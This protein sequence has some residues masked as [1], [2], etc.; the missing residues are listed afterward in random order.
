MCDRTL[1]SAWLL[2]LGDMGVLVEIKWKQVGGGICISPGQNLTI[3]SGCFWASPWLWA[4]PTLAHAQLRK[5]HPL[6]EKLRLQY[7]HRAEGAVCQVCSPAVLNTKSLGAGKMAA[8]CLKAVT[9]EPDDLT[10][11]PGSPWCRERTDSHR[12]CSDLHGTC[13]YTFPPNAVVVGQSW[14]SCQPGLYTC[15]TRQ[16]ESHSTTW[17][18]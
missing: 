10:S 14:T 6:Q 16:I 1:N 3:L 18:F 12:L 8:Q 11:F 2:L 5:I 17:C 7:P 13:T 9:A 15:F 4:A